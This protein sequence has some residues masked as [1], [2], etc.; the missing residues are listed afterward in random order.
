V[1]P[2]RLAS[3]RHVRAAVVRGSFDRFVAIRR[4]GVDAVPH[5]GK[6]FVGQAVSGGQ[7]P[8]PVGRIGVEFAAARLPQVQ[9][10]EGCLEST[11]YC[12]LAVL[13]SSG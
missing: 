13:I 3:L 9:L 7:Q 6:Y 2:E 10:R 8:A 12:E 5:S 1:T 11:T 4:F